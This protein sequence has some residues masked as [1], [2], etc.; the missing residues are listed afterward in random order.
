MKVTCEENTASSRVSHL[1]VRRPF[2]QPF[3]SPDGGSDVGIEQAIIGGFDLM[4]WTR[5]NDSGL[6]R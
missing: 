6:L 4:V 2:G 5:P 3:H 1:P